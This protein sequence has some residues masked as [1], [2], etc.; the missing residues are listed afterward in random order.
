MS[1]LETATPAHA[2][3]RTKETDGEQLT[4]GRTAGGGRRR[5]E[6]RGQGRGRGRRV[7]HLCMDAGTCTLTG[8]RRRVFIYGSQL[9]LH[10]SSII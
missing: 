9:S 5:D 8:H 10:K 4:G 6:E 3:Q 1:P 2:S 7:P